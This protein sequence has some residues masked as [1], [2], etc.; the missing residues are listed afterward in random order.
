MTGKLT[1]RVVQVRDQISNDALR[2]DAKSV[3]NQASVLRA[4]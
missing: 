4:D 1:T 2:L 3:L